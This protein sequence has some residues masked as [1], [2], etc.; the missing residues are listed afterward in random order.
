MKKTLLVCSLVL[1]GGFIGCSEKV[2][3]EKEVE[4]IREVK[5]VPRPMV[6][7]RPR[8]IIVRPGCP[9]HCGPHCPHCG[10]RGIN[11]NIK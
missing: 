3:T 2:Q 4:K 1:L 11:I 6:A 7:P 5:V 10:P 8:P 9:H